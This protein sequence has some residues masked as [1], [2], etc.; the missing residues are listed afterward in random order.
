[1]NN[2][3]LTELYHEQFNRIRQ[4]E[5][6]GVRLRRVRDAAKEFDDNVLMTYHGYS[7]PYRKRLRDALAEVS[8]D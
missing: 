6:A 1:M 7:A 2:K 3:E 8:D 4:L 5:A